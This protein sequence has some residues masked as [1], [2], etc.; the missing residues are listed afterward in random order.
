MATTKKRTRARK[1]V[2][3]R[4][5]DKEQQEDSLQ[6]LHDLSIAAEVVGRKHEVLGKTLRP[7]TLETI[8]LLKQ[9]NS[10]LILGL[11]IEKIENVFLDSCKFVVLQSS[12]KEEARS[13][14]WDEDKLHNVALDFASEVPA[15]E[16]SQLT[17]SINAILMD[18]T[19]TSVDAKPPKGGE[20][21]D[22]LGN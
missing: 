2:K 11:D 12:T 8:I 9:I 21:N 7:V 3:D 1:P 5:T 16:F 10:P 15:R 13:L 4:D 20:N 18:A 17:N 22:P 6:S 14:A 19:S